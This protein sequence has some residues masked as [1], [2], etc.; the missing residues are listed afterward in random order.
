MN[1]WSLTTY[2]N[3]DR[4][5]V[6]LQGEQLLNIEN[7]SHVPARVHH[8]LSHTLTAEDTLN[9]L[10]ALPPTYTIDFHLINLVCAEF[11]FPFHYNPLTYHPF[12]R[13]S[14]LSSANLDTAHTGLFVHAHD[15][16]SLLEDKLA[17]VISTGIHVCL[18]TAH[19]GHTL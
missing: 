8:N 17:S 6:L 15:I 14:Q 18:I 2:D 1:G 16:P 4:S 12:I 19:E 11:L 9:A 7:I 3:H 5:K 13:F 10:Y